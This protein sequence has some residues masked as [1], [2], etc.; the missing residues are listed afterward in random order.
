MNI[1]IVEIYINV[2]EVGTGL[3]IKSF[4]KVNKLSTYQIILLN[5]PQFSK[6]KI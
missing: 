4:G 1:N 2:Q 6:S 3:L 5:K